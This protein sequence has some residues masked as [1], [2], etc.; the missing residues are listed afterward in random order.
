MKTIK[1]IFLSIFI[2]LLL[3]PVVTMNIQSGYASTITNAMLP[4]LDLKNFSR[5]DVDKYIAERIGF[6]DEAITKYLTLYD[7]LFGVLEHPTY[8]YGKEG[9]TFFRPGSD[10]VDTT[11]IDAF[12]QY[13]R[14]I[15]DYCENRGVPFLYCV[16]P[17]KSTVYNEYL[18]EGYLYENRFLSYLY[19]CLEKNGVCY[20]SNVEL[21]TEK[22]Q[23]EQVYNQKYDAGHWNDLGE[24]YATNHMLEA[25]SKS[26]PSVRPWTQSD[27]EISTK[28]ETYLPLS[29][30]VIDEKV[31]QYTYRNSENVEDISALYESINLDP[32]HSAFACFRLKDA[33]DLPRVMFFHG[34]YYNRNRDFYKGAFAETYAIHNYENLLNF[35]YYF[36]IFQ[37]D[38]VVLETVEYATGRGY[39]DLTTMMEKDLNPRLCEVIDEPHCICSLQEVGAV[40]EANHAIKVITFEMEQAYSFGYLETKDGVLDL[41]IDETKISCTV[42][43]DSVSLEGAVIHLYP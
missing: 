22:A 16:N 6:H 1:I 41:I 38:Y 27:F 24:F 11:F 13:L 19:E 7:R 10:W 37:P 43:L 2:V 28:T 33:S 20:I 15:Q 17:A 18:P 9:Y 34:S 8:T 30:F 25:I 31:P 32:S 42:Q 3:V 40:T 4:E 35:E 5:E 23:N 36:N 14:E 39:F 26:F 29:Q 12:C 21:L